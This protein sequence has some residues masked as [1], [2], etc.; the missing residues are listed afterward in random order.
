V[1]ITYAFSQPVLVKLLN[2][3]FVGEWKYLHKACFDILEQRANRALLK[4]ALQLRLIDDEEKLS[5]YFRSIKEA[6][7]RANSHGT[8]IKKRKNG[9]EADLYFRDV[10]NKILHSSGIDWKFD[11]PDN[12]VIICHSREPDQWVRAE[13]QVLCLAALVGGL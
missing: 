4:L 7:G 3:K 11:D 2:T 12:P 9:T 8:V 1:I 6:T 5:D 13:I 10:T